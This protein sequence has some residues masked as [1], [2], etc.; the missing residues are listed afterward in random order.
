MIK[1]ISKARLAGL[2]ALIA[3][4]ALAAPATLAGPETK[5][6]D[7]K[8]TACC[9]NC[10]TAKATKT[11]KKAK[12]PK[13]TKQKAVKKDV[14]GSHLKQ[15]SVVARFPETTSPVEVWDRE[16]MLRSGEATLSGFLSRQ[17]VFR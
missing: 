9:G 16:V 5:C 15:R 2:A 13:Q 11:A 8:T 12:A 7:P 6:C 1:P 17:S 4:F 3:G 14:T 10:S